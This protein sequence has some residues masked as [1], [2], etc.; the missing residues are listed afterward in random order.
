MFK[1][2]L[3]VFVALSE[4][5]CQQLADYPCLPEQ[6]SL[7]SSRRGPA[8]EEE[9]A[10]VQCTERPATSLGSGGHCED[11]VC[12]GG[13]HRGGEGLQAGFCYWRGRCKPG[14]KVLTLRFGLTG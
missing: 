5:V 8:V 10:G 1:I 14:K 7:L 4:H 3:D 6:P 13:P 2:K 12:P 9:G 11:A